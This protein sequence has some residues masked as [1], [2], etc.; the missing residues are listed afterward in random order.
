MT[1]LRLPD[2]E[3]LKKQSEEFHLTILTRL[4]RMHHLLEDIQS[5]LSFLITDQDLTFQKPEAKQ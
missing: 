1:E 3:D 2:L 5:R 4:A